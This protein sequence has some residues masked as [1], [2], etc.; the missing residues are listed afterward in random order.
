MPMTDAEYQAFCD[1]LDA[2]REAANPAGGKKSA[3]SP[4]MILALIQSILSAVGPIF[5]GGGGAGPK[6]P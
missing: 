4:A 6:A 1:K 5:S 2:I 3:L